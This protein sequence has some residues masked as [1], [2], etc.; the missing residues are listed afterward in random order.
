M[1]KS[2]VV[3]GRDAPLQPGVLF[4]VLDDGSVSVIDSGVPRDF[5]TRT[6]ASSPES[7]SVA[8][9]STAATLAPELDTGFSTPLGYFQP[10]RSE[11]MPLPQ[12]RRFSGM[13]PSMVRQ[14]I[15]GAANRLQGTLGSLN[16][17]VE[18][19]ISAAPYT[20]VVLIGGG[21]SIVKGRL[22]GIVTSSTTTTTGN[23]SG[24]PPSPP[25]TST[26][27]TEE[28]TTETTNIQGMFGARV[29]ALYGMANT[30][31]S[32]L[33]DTLK[34]AAVAQ[35]LIMLPVRFVAALQPLREKAHQAI[36]LL[37]DESV[38]LAELQEELVHKNINNITKFTLLAALGT[39][40]VMVLC[41]VGSIIALVLGLATFPI[42]LGLVALFVIEARS[43]R[44]A[45]VTPG[46]PSSISISSLPDSTQSSPRL[47]S[48]KLK[49]QL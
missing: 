17:Y 42:F 6:L 33:N 5:D 24:S 26:S 23:L 32:I 29:G 10:T 8:S 4:Q 12:N 11:T 7:L 21:I 44:R 13:L 40:G 49:L 43:P 3:S 25:T 38:G 2:R 9:G 30:G 46:S 35:D 16:R 22:S 36:D 34:A 28:Q 48:Q 45:M 39:G 19:A 18:G 41:F 27:M 15:R 20:P 14:P 1:G 37:T 47:A 31:T